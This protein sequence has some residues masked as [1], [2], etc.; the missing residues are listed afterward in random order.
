[1]TCS[2]KTFALEP[3]DSP[4]QHTRNRKMRLSSTDSSQLALLSSFRASNK[5]HERAANG[6]ASGFNIVSPIKKSLRSL[7]NL[8]IYIP[9]PP[10]NIS[11][12]AECA[13]GCLCSYTQCA[14]G[15]K[16]D[17][18]GNR[19]QDKSKSLVKRAKSSVKGVQ[20]SVMESISFLNP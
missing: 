11:W 12:R 8:G 18:D 7:R 19:A 14:G 20:A 2:I 13:G 16:G 5:M 1:M 10:Q 3:G 4:A 6:K 17:C 9:N 15:S